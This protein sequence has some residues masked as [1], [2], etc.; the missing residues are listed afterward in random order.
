MGIWVAAQVLLILCMGST[1]D[2]FVN[3]EPPLYAEGDLLDIP[4]D[5][6]QPIIAEE[7]KPL[8]FPEAMQKSTQIIVQFSSD[9]GEMGTSD[10]NWTAFCAGFP[11]LNLTENI[12]MLRA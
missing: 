9:L 7:E 1:A 3:G 4:E 2:E 6:E 11:E 8:V 5:G 10:I 12:T